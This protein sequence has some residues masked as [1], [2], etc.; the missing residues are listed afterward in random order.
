MSERIEWL[1]TQACVPSGCG[2]IEAARELQRIGRR[3]NDGRL[4]CRGKVAELCGLIVG[5]SPTQF[6]FWTGV[7][8]LS[9]WLVKRK[10]IWTIDGDRSCSCWPH[11]VLLSDY[12]EGGHSHCETCMIVDTMPYPLLDRWTPP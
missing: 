10:Y 8:R 5:V 4:W 11:G 7:S 2:D 9:W 12:P 6:A 3:T 1:I